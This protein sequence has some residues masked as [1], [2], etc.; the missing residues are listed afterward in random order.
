MLLSTVLFNKKGTNSILTS[1][2]NVFF[3]QN[4]TEV[5]STAIT[6]TIRIRIIYHTDDKTLK[7][8]FNFHG[9][10]SIKSAV[11]ESSENHY[12]DRDF[13]KN[14]HAVYSTNETLQF[15][16]RHEIRN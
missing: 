15:K 8:V 10:C 14:H 2:K 12:A 11:G 16:Q 1:P 6:I 7:T 5:Q 13:I 9:W 3:P 4:A